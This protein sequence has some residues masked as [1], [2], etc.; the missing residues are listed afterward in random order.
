LQLQTADGRLHSLLDTEYQQI[1][2]VKTS[3]MPPLKAKPA[4]RRDLMA[5]LRTLD[6]IAAGPLEGEHEPIA[7][8]P[9]NPGDWPTYYGSFSGNRHSPLD[10]INI[11]N[12]ARLN[13]QWS[14]S[15]PYFL[16][17]TTPLVIDGVM[18][19]TG[20]N[21]VIALDARTGRKIWSYSRP[22]T[23]AGVIAGDAALG[24]NRGVAAL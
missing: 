12:A 1:T 17:E 6:G 10:Q 22:R 9:T 21:Q 23:P 7:T 4:E 20:P 2:T 15:I 18:Y 3:A 5:Y 8:H 16:L 13:L 24:A 14:Y 11:G 19:V